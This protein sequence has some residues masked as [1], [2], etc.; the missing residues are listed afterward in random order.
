MDN[1][2][3][4]IFDSGLGG[5][6]AAETLR[7]LMPDENIV[8]FGDTGRCPYGTRGAEELRKMAREDMEF[9]AARGAKA[10]IAAC[11]TVSSTAPE[12]LADFR[13]PVVNVIDASV[14]A[15]ASVPG[16]APIGVI[17]TSAS[18]ENG[19]FKRRLAA[20]CT[21]RPIIALACQDFV[22]LIEDGHS[23]SG[24]GAVIASVEENLSPM[25][26][27]GVGVLLLGC[28]HFGLIS[29]AIA[30][31]MGDGVTLI[32]AAE[33]AARAMSELLTSRG[34]QGCG[35]GEK[36]YTS[37]SAESFGRYASRLLG[38]DVSALVHK[39]AA[40]ETGQ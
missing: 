3:V 26:E 16:D 9:L 11:G 13:L 32:D 31:Y 15:A 23:G 20:L 19:A 25:K 12:V 1:R 39:A 30:D 10:I 36:Y 38:R 4:G 27:T 35:A 22:R 8:Y 37:G 14:A 34:I 6:T 24:D 29:R 33:C 28:T 18:I 17:A 2:P 5:L 7:K 21:D 40:K